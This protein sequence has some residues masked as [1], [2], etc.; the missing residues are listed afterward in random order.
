MK[1]F[2]NTKEEYRYIVKIIDNY[3]ESGISGHEIAVIS[4][5]EREEVSGILSYEE[6][7]NSILEYDIFPE[8]GTGVCVSSFQGCKGLEFK[9]VIIANYHDIENYFLKDMENEWYNKQ[10]LKQ[11]ECLKYVA[12]TRA[13]DELIVTYVK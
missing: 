7:E 13:R 8:E 6:I 3:L 2:K 12:C 5:T 10:K 9:V 4:P 1:S 11:I